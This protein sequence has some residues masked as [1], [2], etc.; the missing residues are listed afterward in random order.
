MTWFRDAAATIAEVDSVDPSS[1]STVD[2]VHGSKYLVDL[3]YQ[4]S[5][6]NPVQSSGSIEVTFAADFTLVP[7]F[8][9]PL[10]DS[11]LSETFTAKF[12]YVEAAK[13][14]TAMIRLTPQVSRFF[15][16]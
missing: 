13:D 5:V 11:Y 16:C 8:Y 9:Q 12:T 7:F 2:L 1:V 6:C 3:F 15:V 4:D 10:A 14:G